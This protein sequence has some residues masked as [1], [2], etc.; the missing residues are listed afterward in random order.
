MD[1]IITKGMIMNGYHDIGNVM[2][3]AQF[4]KKSA[5]AVGFDTN[6]SI[7]KAFDKVREEVEEL[8]VELDAGTDFTN[9][10]KEL[11]DV[12]FALCGLANKLDI[13]AEDCLNMTIKK[14]VYRSRYVEKKLEDN[15][16]NFSNGDINEMCAWWNEAKKFI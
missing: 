3:R 12:I 11:G 4:V 8:K 2:D 13:S 1:D 15:G 9:I 5:T 6:D 10:Q 16:Q 7:E 14:F